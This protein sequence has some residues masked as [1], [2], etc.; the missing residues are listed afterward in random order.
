MTAL[1]LAVTISSFSHSFIEG[2]ISSPEM[3]KQGNVDDGLG[4][5]ISMHL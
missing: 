5:A 4:L 2:L 1:A 3:A